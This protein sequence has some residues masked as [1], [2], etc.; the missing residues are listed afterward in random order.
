MTGAMRLVLHL[1][2]PASVLVALIVLTITA[3]YNAF[4]EDKFLSAIDDFPLM[5]ELDE[6]TGGVMVFDSPSGRIVEALTMGKVTKEKVQQFYSATLPQLG[7]KETTPGEF[8]RDGEILKMEFP[9]T[10]AHSGAT[11]T[12]GASTISVLFML[13]PAK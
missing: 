8:S 4:G 5:M 9:Q 10:L 7:W 1:L 2:K 12:E 3:P 6:I 13:S 11:P